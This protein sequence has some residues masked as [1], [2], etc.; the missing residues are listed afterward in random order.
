M[1]YGYTSLLYANFR[2]ITMELSAL[3]PVLGTL[4]AALVAGTIARANL[5]VSKESKIS[6]FRHADTGALRDELAAFL[7][8]A[9]TMARAAQEARLAVDG[10]NTKFH[11]SAEK[12]TEIRHEA[13]ET[14]SKIRLRLDQGK[15]E[16]NALLDSL[17]TLIAEQNKYLSGQHDDIE[18]IFNA[19]NT[20]SEKAAQVLRSEW[21][22]VK[23]G[24]LQYRNAVNVAT[25]MLIT[26]G[27]LIVV[28][29]A[30]VLVNEKTEIK[31]NTS[32]VGAAGAAAKKIGAGR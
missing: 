30:V 6:E 23:I 31:D 8:S 19:L 3:F 15:H 11:I 21:A 4:A 29:L 10:I 24:E 7:A 9:R 27:V 12:I 18:L 20:A 22:A 5:I 13:A 2:M 17:N 16:Q 26:G 28:L 32:Q 14:F 1:E 25:A